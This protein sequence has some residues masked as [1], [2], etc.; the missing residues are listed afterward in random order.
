M[1]D[2]DSTHT[3]AADDSLGVM[4][5]IT[6][7]R[8]D[9]DSR[10]GR[11]PLISKSN[12]AQDDN[13]SA[14]VENANSL[15]ASST[16]KMLVVSGIVLVAGLVGISALL[17][18]TR[19]N[20]MAATARVE[21]LEA[22]LVTTDTSLTKSEV[23]LAA[24]L[25]AMDAQLDSNKTEINKLANLADRQ[26]KHLQSQT[27]ELQQQKSQS[28]STAEQLKQTV[29]Q[30]A[31]DSTRLTNV[32]NT[33]KETAQRME[34]VQ[35]NL[36]DLKGDTGA[37]KEKQNALENET[38]KRLTALEDTAKSTDVFRRNTLDEL[39]KLRDEVSR[40]ATPP[41]AGAKPA[42]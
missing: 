25:K 11:H 37:L 1:S 4:P 15:R 31:A 5:S 18:Q 23:L 29:S 16:N 36:G 13:R 42:P 30:V 24:K 2:K 40:L 28:K 27:A 12:K 26:A 38:G 20:L 8:E 17:Y 10:R 7:E 9:I 32:D 41:A 21:Q 6:P 33:A 34:I 19:Q 3:H 14:A 39:R 22:R 35:E